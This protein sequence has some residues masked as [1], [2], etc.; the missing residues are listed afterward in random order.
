MQASAPMQCNAHQSWPEVLSK[1]SPGFFC[2]FTGPACGASASK[3]LSTLARGSPCESSCRAVNI[4]SRLRPCV[5]HG[6]PCHEAATPCVGSALR[7][8]SDLAAHS[9]RRICRSATRQCAARSI[10]HPLSYEALASS[11]ALASSRHKHCL[12]KCRH[13]HTNGAPASHSALCQ[14]C[15]ILCTGTTA[16]TSTVQHVLPHLNPLADGAPATCCTAPATERCQS[17]S[18]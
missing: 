15:A 11:C 5:S 4:V 13:A 6:G 12:C 16:G 8:V 9:P 3:S 2:T 1:T 18:S 10:A 17:A 7:S 14:P